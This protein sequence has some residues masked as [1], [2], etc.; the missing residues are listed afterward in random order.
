MASTQISKILIANR[1]EIACR[2]MRTAKRMGIATI[3]VYSDADA[4]ALHVR[5]AD[6]AV[7]IGPAPASES[8][9]VID[10]IIEAAKATSADAIH[11]GYGFLSENPAFVRACEDA[12][13]TFMGPSADAMEAMGLKDAAKALMSEAGVPVTP[14]YQGD[15]QDPDFLAEQASEIGYPVLIKAVAGG[16]G[17]GMR[18][19]EAAEDFKAALA[20]CQREAASSF[21]NDHVLI[22]KFIASPRHIE[23]QI[24]GDTHCNVIHLFERDCSVQR[25]HQKVIE[26]AP[27]PGMTEDV[28][29]AMTEA[30]VR[31]AK[32][33]NYVGAGTVEFIVDGSGPLRTDGFWFM[34]MNTRLQV[35]HPVT[36]EITGLDLVELQIRVA[37]G[38]SLPSQDSLSIDGHAIEARLYAEDPETDFTPSVGR[39]HHFKRPD[40]IRIDTGFE[41]GDHVS[42]HYD[43]MIAKLI[44]HANTREEAI[45]GLRRATAKTSTYPVKTNAAFLQAILKTDD[46]RNAKLDT[47]FIATHD[48]TGKQ[49]RLEKLAK[50]IGPVPQA[51]VFGS[52]SGWRINGPRQSVMHAYVDGEVMELPL[53][54][55]QGKTGIIRVGNRAVHIG[56]PSDLLDAAL[57]ADNVT[58]PM[59]GKVIAILVEPGETVTADQ[60]LVIL[61]AMKMEMTLKSPR[62]GVVETVSAEAGALVDDGAALVKLE[63]A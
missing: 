14:G 60:P 31:A 11:P 16:G 8:Y 3:A 47:S 26:E 48:L 62:D 13:I 12:G 19:V 57:G 17:K 49:L 61:E 28:R 52:V 30:A 33:V 51:G 41:P 25:R 29:E 15:N 7:H 44:V 40:D 43:P 58:A 1:G 27:A 63:E 46:F 39:L 56:M 36:E 37:R 10:K 38:E 18:K 45:D 4:D 6:E 5:E 20:S 9:L 24:F 54:P 50:R 2:V 42:R 55:G 21:G 22:E 53:R 35:E 34:E 23:V 59:P 32:A